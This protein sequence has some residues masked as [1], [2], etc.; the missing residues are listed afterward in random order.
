MTK[1]D[2]IQE[3]EQSLILA[4]RILNGMRAAHRR[5]VSGSGPVPVP[6][7]SDQK[8]LRPESRTE[9][10]APDL[11]SARSVCE[12]YLDQVSRPW[13]SVAGLM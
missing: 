1:L 13:I 3:P 9:R 7:P 6:V 12:A 10:Y 2:L 11:R 4:T 5:S 8:G